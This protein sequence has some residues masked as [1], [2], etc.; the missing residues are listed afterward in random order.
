MTYVF[1]TLLLMTVVKMI[2]Q[3]DEKSDPGKAGR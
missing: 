1:G 2:L 3:G